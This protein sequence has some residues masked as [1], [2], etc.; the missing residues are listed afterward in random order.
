[1]WA[2][3]PSKPWDR[4]WARGFRDGHLGRRVPRCEGA[5]G[6][7][8]A[9]AWLRRGQRAVTA[10]G[11]DQRSAPGRATANQ[12]KGGRRGWGHTWERKLHLQ[13]MSPAAGLWAKRW[14]KKPSSPSLASPPL[15]AGKPKRPPAAFLRRP[16][17]T[18]HDFVQNAK[19]T[20]FK[21]HNRF[22]RTN[23][24]RIGSPE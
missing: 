14:T 21:V 12:S 10:G 15:A 4:A 1:M 20:P 7:P 18:K 8:R 9:Q 11:P 17:L 2:A 22:H 23:S 16:L 24:E 13:A 3:V 6:C 19:E 5:R